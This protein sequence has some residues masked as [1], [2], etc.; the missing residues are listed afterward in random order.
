M[1]LEAPRVE[2][3]DDE[4]LPEEI[5]AVLGGGPMLNIFRTLAHHPKLLKRWLVFG[6]HILG[7]NTLPERDRELVILRI[8]WL[9]GSEYEWTQHAAI[10]KL[11][12]LSDADIDRIAIGSK[13]EGLDSFDRV[14]LR[15]VEELH[16]DCFLSDATWQALAER[17]DTPQIIDLIFTVGQYQLVSMA[18]NSLGVQLEDG[19]ERL[20]PGRRP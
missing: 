8:G 11:A 16:T 10:G 17:Y 12:G 3:L 1:R 13:A 14:Q 7:K 9:C 18:L 2:P 19:M 5:R 20:P 4:A 15:A 6:S